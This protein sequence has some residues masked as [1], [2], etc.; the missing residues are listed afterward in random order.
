MSIII[1]DAVTDVGHHAFAN[2]TSLTNAVIGNGVT[3]VEEGE[4][5]TCPNLSHVAMGNSVVSIGSFAFR[6][7]SLASVT[8][9]GSVRAIGEWAFHSIAALTN[10]YFQGS[11]P[12]PGASMFEGDDYATV[13]YLPGTTGWGPFF[14]NRPTALWNPQV[15]SGGASFGAQAGGFGFTVTGTV[16]LVIVVD[17]CTN[18]AN[19]AWYP[20]QTNTLTNGSAFFSDPQWT[21]YPARFYRLRLG[22]V[23]AVGRHLA[24]L[25]DGGGG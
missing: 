12:H 5:D 14:A 3:I 20:L 15:Q 23:L 4:F 18:L 2:C 11:A 10:V 1:P 17:A 22:C 25:D 13:Y 7:S 16:G 8:I 19:P 24:I 6:G 9:P 21:N